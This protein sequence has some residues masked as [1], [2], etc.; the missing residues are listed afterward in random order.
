MRGGAMQ[1]SIVANGN[2][3]HAEL[4]GAFFLC[5]VERSRDISHSPAPNSKRF[6]DFARNDR[7][8]SAATKSGPPGSCRRVVQIPPEKHSLGQRRAGHSC[9]CRAFLLSS[10]SHDSFH[11]QNPITAGQRA[12]NKSSSADFAHASAAACRLC[13]SQPNS[14][15][16]IGLVGASFV[17]RGYTSCILNASFLFHHASSA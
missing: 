15:R 16:T 2:V 13:R 5:H 17:R 11:Q 14:A 1:V 10:F 7:G 3:N 8:T 12:E 6:L 4:C 9:R